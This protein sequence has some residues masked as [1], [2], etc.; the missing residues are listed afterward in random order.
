MRR[1]FILAFLLLLSLPFDAS[2]TGCYRNPAG[3]F[4]NGLGYGLSNSNIASITLQPEVYGISLAYAQTGQLQSPTAAACHGSVSVSSYSYGTTDINIA[5]V[6]PSGALCAGTWNR[7]SGQGIADFTTCLPTNKTGVAY[8]TA[9]AGGVTSNVVPVYVHPPVTD[10][11][12]DVNGKS[13]G[14]AGQPTQTANGCFSQGQTAQLNATAYVEGKNTPFCAPAGNSASVPDCSTNLGHLTYSP[15]TSGIVTIDQNGVAT[16][17][18]PG[19]TVVTATISGV[20]SNAGYYYTC[21]PKTIS[22]QTAAGGTNLSVTPNTPVS[23]TASILDTN[24]RPITGLQLNYTSTNPQTIGIS[25]TGTV[26]S[27]F[28]STSAVYA[29]CQPPTCNPS[30]INQIGVNGNGTPVV[31]NAVTVNSPGFASSYLWLASPLSPYFVAVDLTTGTTGT[32]VRL[33]FNPNSMVLDQEGLFL[34]FGSYRELMVY[35]AA[36]NS[37]TNQDSSVPGVVLAVSPDGTTAVINDQDRQVIYLYSTKNNTILSTF[38]GVAQRARFSPDSTT[39]YLVGD[40]VMYVHNT[41]TGWSVEPLPNG[42]ATASTTCSLT[43]NPVDPTTP[44]PDANTAYNRY[45]SPDLAL[46]VPGVG[47]FLS[48]ATTSARGFCPNTTGTTVDNYPQANLFGFP[49]DQIGATNDGLHLLGATPSALIDQAITTP[50]GVCPSHA[51]ASPSGAPGTVGLTFGTGSV[52]QLSLAPYGIQ[53]VDQV[54]PSPDSSVAFITYTSAATRPPAGGALLPA[55]KLTGAQGGA[56]TLTSVPLAGS[57][58]API[59]GIFSPDYQT[60]FVSTSGDNL[61][62]LIDT[63]GLKDTSQFN[64]KLPDVNGNPTPVQLLATKPRPTV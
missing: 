43:P 9:S 38:G 55:Y 59:A 49:S 29:V 25:S 56:G 62:H 45:C 26:T 10:I 24:D 17:Q 1:Y 63:K 37:I 60:F 2:L 39:V 14:Q 51:S 41:F 42:T 19:S 11:S 22:L 13:P 4:C 27:S 30:P 3:N 21:P 28:P 33:P 6:S 34:Y 61:I 46:A 23:L 7:N 44:A 20:S 50:T 16:A 12:L 5:D 53:N 31:S 8:L 47:A 58:V 52:S 15:V 54:V 40:G 35:S 36:N 64:P 57:A 48:G 18:L 32:P